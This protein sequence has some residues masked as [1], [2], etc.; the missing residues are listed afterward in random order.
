MRTVVGEER[1]D[2]PVG[3]RSKTSGFT[4]DGA[5]N[6]M[7]IP[8][9]FWRREAD[10]VAGGGGG[11]GLVKNAE[12]RDRSGRVMRMGKR[13]IRWV[14]NSGRIRVVAEKRSGEMVVGGL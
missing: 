3:G 8:S 1:G 14:K 6:G 4:R 5:G 7:G 2:L 10:G 12:F 13:R 9:I 11:E